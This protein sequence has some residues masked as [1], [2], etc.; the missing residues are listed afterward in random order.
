MEIMVNMTMGLTSMAQQSTNP[1]CSAQMIQRR[2]T[3]KQS[4]GS[5][6]GKEELKCYNRFDNNYNGAATMTNA[7]AFSSLQVADQN[8][9][10]WFPD[11]GASAH[12]TASTTNLQAAETYNGNDTVM[13]ADGTYLLITHMGSVTLSNTS[14]KIYLNDV[15]VCPEIQKSLLSVSKLCDDY[16]CGVYFDA[17]KVCVIDLE[18]QRVVS[19]GPR[20]NGLYVLENQEVVALYSSRQ[21]AADAEGLAPDLDTQL[22][23][24][25]TC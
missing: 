14:G 2:D 18:T 4:N 24:R 16:P 11:S 25:F 3:T 17:S 21:C 23:T 20:R 6:Y 1:S 9:K 12:V 10:E 7:Q 13:V 22:L 5:V 8:G 15:L 19:K